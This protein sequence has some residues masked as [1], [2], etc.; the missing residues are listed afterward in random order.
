MAR[1]RAILPTLLVLMT[2]ASAPLAQAD[3][4]DP[5]YT[6]E[7]CVEA[8]VEAS[9]LAEHERQV[10]SQIRGRTVYLSWPGYRDQLRVEVLK[11][12]RDAVPPL[13]AWLKSD[14]DALWALGFLKDLAPYLR[15]DDFPVLRS[16]AE[17]TG[18]HLGD[19]WLAVMT[20]H[21]D[22]EA[23]AAPHVDQWSELFFSLGEH[24]RLGQIFRRAHHEKIVESYTRDAAR[25]DDSTRALRTLMFEGDLSPADARLVVDFVLNPAAHPRDRRKVLGWLSEFGMPMTSVGPQLPRLH[26]Y[27]LSEPPVPSVATLDEAEGLTRFRYQDAVHI[28]GSDGQVLR[29]FDTL[30]EEIKSNLLSLGYRPVFTHFVTKLEN[31]YYPRTNYSQ[32]FQRRWHSLG[33]GIVLHNIIADPKMKTRVRTLLSKIAA[34]PYAAPEERRRAAGALKRIGPSTFEYW[35]R[36]ALDRRLGE[37]RMEPVYSA[38]VAGGP[39]AV[40]LLN[41]VREHAYDRY[42]FEHAGILLRVAPAG[43]WTGN[44]GEPFHRY[45][46]AFHDPVVGASQTDG[47]SPQRCPGASPVWQGETVAL[48]RLPYAEDGRLK[49]VNPVPIDPAT[50]RGL[51]PGHGETPVFHAVQKVPGG[52]LVG[53]S[54]TEETGALFF[55]APDGTAWMLF[56]QIAAEILPDPNAADGTAFLV[57]AANAITPWRGGVLRVGRTGPP[58]FHGGWEAKLAGWLRDAPIGFGVM[59]D[60]TILTQ[61]R[62]G[63]VFALTQDGLEDADCPAPEDP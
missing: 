22:A 3:E 37:M 52:H 47:P 50:V 11:Y 36:Q 28:R 49:T 15:P 26:A 62:W 41:K 44:A 45:F 23:W 54:W 14:D 58:N 7:A 10:A 16:F 6:A 60:G 42:L 9:I 39:K 13:M 61:D 31:A 8:W 33:Q 20:G 53:I 5:C 48:E 24:Y 57:V 38:A 43:P 18:V 25:T 56:D 34:D 35:S 2:C 19:L 1:R 40:P 32:S 17:R 29:F 46:A 21:P 30:G 4:R 55:V 12:G 51:G 63:A 59:E 27:A